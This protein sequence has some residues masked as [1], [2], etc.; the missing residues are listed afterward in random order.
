[1]VLMFLCLVLD[2]GWKAADSGVFQPLRPQEVLINEDG[3]L[4]LLDF[5]EARVILYDTDGSQIKTFGRKGKG[6]G[7]FGLP[8]G[9][10][11]QKGKLYIQDMLT[12]SISVFSKD[13]SFEKRVK[14]PERGL[15]MQKT[16]NGWI[17]AR[18]AGF[19]GHGSTPKLYVVDE[20]FENPVELAE[21]T[22][23]GSGSGT[24][25]MNNNGEMTARYSPIER[26]PR[27]LASPDGRTAYL[28]DP[29]T[30][31]LR[32]FN[33]SEGKE[34][35]PI[36]RDE[37]RIPFDT[38]WADEEYERGAEGRQLPANVKVKK[39]YPDAFPSIRNIRMLNDG[40]MVVDR[41]MGRPG[42]NHHPI[43]L[44]GKGETVDLPFTWGTVQRLV[45]VH[46]GYA[47]ITMFQEGDEEG[48]VTRVPV[49][50]ADQFVKDNPLDPEAD[51][52]RNITLS[53]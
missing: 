5:D 22:D 11:Y 45:G 53:L 25:I 29:D 41:W 33:L 7:E 52:S 31:K 1:M 23:P 21:I 34:M 39:L 32:V 16:A 48:W 50:Q 28:S 51:F 38:E 20:N 17:Y 15:K 26:R 12:Q 18:L 24:M 49:A 14:L 13:G 10:F 43:A 46:K 19:M 8:M 9:M 47:Y 4:Y 3:Q 2:G 40:T 30:F 42:E 36:V 27:L 6:P 37:Q 44:N 35:D